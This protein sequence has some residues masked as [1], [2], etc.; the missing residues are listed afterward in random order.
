MKKI[1]VIIIGGGLAGLTAAI[2]LRILGFEIQ[3]VEPNPYPKHKVCGEYISN[4]VKPYLTS[5]G[6]DVHEAGA[7]DIKRFQLTNTKNK[8]IEADL[9][10]GGFGISRYTLDKLMADRAIELGVEI[11]QDK[12]TNVTYGGNSFKVELKKS[13]SPLIST[14]VV[15]AYGKRSALD[16]NLGRRFIKERTPWI[17]VKSHYEG[18]FPEDLVSLNHFEGGYCGLSNVENQIVN[19]CYLIHQSTFQKYRNIEDVQNNVLSANPFVAE[20]YASSKMLFDKP[21]SISQIYFGKRDLVYNH[22]LMIGDTGGMIHPLA[23]NGMAIAIHSAKLAS[24][25]VALYL[26]G[27]MSKEEMENKYSAERK[28]AFAKRI[29]AGAY[30]QSLFEKQKLSHQLMQLVHYVP[31]IVP[32]IIRLT[33]GKTISTLDKSKN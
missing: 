22:I 4:E 27:K 11:I 17:G 24:E 29:R 7:K 28:K 3:V 20:F 23:G 18:T 14:L 30:I 25:S 9:P 15:G 16:K 8:S 31:F 1:D 26:E 13:S 5:L 6:I 12:V 10:L 32:S 21:I 2:H 19:A 33:H